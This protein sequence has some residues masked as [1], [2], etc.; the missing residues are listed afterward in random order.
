MRTV[1]YS[2]NPKTGFQAIVNNDGE[3]VE[4]LQPEES[5]GRSM[6]DKA[7]RDYGKYYDFS[8]DDFDSFSN[9]RK[10]SKHPFDTVFKDY[11]QNKRPKYPSDLEPSDFSHSITIKHPR[12]DSGSHS[13]SHSHFGLDLDPN[14]KKKHKKGISS[15]SYGNVVEFDANKPDDI[16]YPFFSPDAYKD[17]YEKFESSN[18]DYEK[19]PYGS[20]HKIPKFE[21][22][23]PEYEKFLQSYN[24]KVPKLEEFNFRPSKY[25]Y[26]YVPDIPS[27]D[28]YPDDAPLRPKK[29]QRPQ[30][31]PEFHY[32]SED[33]DDYMWVPKKKRIPPRIV[34]PSDYVPESEEEYDRP[35][36]PSDF[37]DDER[38]HREREPTRGTG[39]KKEVI[40]KIVKKRKPGFNLLDILDI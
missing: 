32:P 11:S 38:P 28:Y 24:S 31:T 4:P 22:S 1:E 33:I 12:D 40:R 26:P 23:G 29:K 36:Y 37:E 7:L 21:P 19:L 3:K 35:R 18:V 17:D 8:D 9:E 27:H 34:D 25:K 2:A 13:E 5:I 14:C 39:P 16:K 15:T 6:Q 30:K 10:K 20:R